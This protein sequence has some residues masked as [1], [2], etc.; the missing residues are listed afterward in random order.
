MG[1]Y[2]ANSLGVGEEIKYSARVSLWRYWLNFLLGGPVL[3]AALSALTR[4]VFLSQHQD[5]ASAA[6]GIALGL[7]SISALLVML[8]PF[9]AR[10]ATEVVIT[11]KR[12]V[13]KF[14][15]LSTHSIEMRFDKIETVRVAQ[16]LLGRLLNFGDVTVTGTGA[17][18]DPMPMIAHPLAFRTALNQAMELGKPSGG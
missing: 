17:T 3:L 15:L 5:G 10:R 18:F 14:G 11:N 1:S 7:V 6:P 13:A 12:V 2:V 8:W 9:L 16:S 4:S